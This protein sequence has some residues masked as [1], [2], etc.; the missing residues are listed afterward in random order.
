ME[1]QQL[2]KMNDAVSDDDD[3]EEYIIQRLPI[4]LINLIGKWIH[5]DM[6]H[7][8]ANARQQHWVIDVDSIIASTH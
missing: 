7:L 3:D 6:V 5:N 4:Y 8:I 1:H 2:A